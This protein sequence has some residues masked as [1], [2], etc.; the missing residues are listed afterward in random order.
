MN[1][2]SYTNDEANIIWD[3]CYLTNNAKC[4]VCFEQNISRN[5][6]FVLQKNNR[7]KKYKRNFE[8]GYLVSLTNGGIHDPSNMCPMC[9]KCNKEMQNINFME[10]FIT[11]YVRICLKKFMRPTIEEIYYYFANN[12]VNWH[13]LVMPEMTRDCRIWILNNFYNYLCYLGCSHNFISPSEEEIYNWNFLQR[14]TQLNSAHNFHQQI[15]SSFIEVDNISC[16]N[17]HSRNFQR[18][19]TPMFNMYNWNF[20][21]PETHTMTED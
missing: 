13:E 1:S 19:E 10:Y 17:M 4:I 20:Q 12:T 16:Y 9:E 21:P 7:Q 5:P 3:N 15:N 18:T 2:Y 11:N 8:I 14:E 6:N